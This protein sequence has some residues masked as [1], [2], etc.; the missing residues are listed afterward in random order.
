MTEPRITVIIPTRERRETLEASIRTCVEQDYDNLE[1]IVSDN[2]SQDDTEAVARSFNDPRLKYIKT[3]RR[4]SMTG[5]FEFALGHV[6]P[7]YVSIIGDDDGFIPGALSVLGQWA[8]ATGTDAISWHAAA[9][10]WPTHSL[11][12]SRGQLQIPVLDL[13]W[14]VSAKAALTAA[15]WS[16]LRWNYLP[17]LYGGLV[18]LE[19]M[20]KLR[21]LTGAYLLSH[22]PDVYSAI[23]ICSVI[24]KYI[25]TEYPFSTFGFSGKSN[26]S[27]MHATVSTGI[28][29]DTDA[30]AVFFKENTI[31]PHPYLPV[32]DMR[33]ESAAMV[34]CL[35]RVKE[36]IFNGRLFVPDSMWL[37]RLVREARNFGEPLRSEMLSR[38]ELLVRQHHREWLVHSLLALSSAK[39]KIQRSSGA[40][41]SSGAASEHMLSGGRLNIDAGKFSVADIYGACGLVAKLRPLPAE[42]PTFTEAGLGKLL[43][44]RW[45]P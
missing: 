10:Y 32:G 15:K 20:N 29:T 3:D 17:I 42:V 38:L 9:Y 27:S 37:Y 26:A 22:I 1:I 16:F 41:A 34:D 33:L 18:K 6:R 28:A 39:A 19:V 8:R 14:N 24:E 23:A 43:K 11:P 36:A 4:L 2:V 30:T 31:A 45:A 35:Y 12:A 5:N 13:D 21:Q 25:Y 7:G 44:R 40:A